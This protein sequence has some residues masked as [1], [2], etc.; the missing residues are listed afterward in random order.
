MLFAQTLAA[1]K[2]RQDTISCDA[3]FAY[4]QRFNCFFINF[5]SIS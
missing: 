3:H 2:P 4:W 5:V 1:I